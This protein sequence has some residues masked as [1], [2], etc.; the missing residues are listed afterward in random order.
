MISLIYDCGILFINIFFSSF[1]SSFILT[2][3]CEKNKMIEYKTGSEKNGREKKLIKQ[4]NRKGE[5]QK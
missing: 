2:L 1:L 3:H 5:K 4:E